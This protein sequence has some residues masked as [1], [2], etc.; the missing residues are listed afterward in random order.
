MPRK[1]PPGM[2]SYALELLT[3]I[4]DR[5]GFYSGLESVDRYLWETARSHLAKGDSVTRVLVGADAL[6]LKQI[7]GYFTLSTILV[8]ATP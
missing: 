2:L 6:P 7:L 3:E 1:A 4:H 5:A 8:E